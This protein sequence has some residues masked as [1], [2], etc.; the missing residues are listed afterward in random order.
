HQQSRWSYPDQDTVI[1]IAHEFRSRAIP[2]DTIVLDID[3]MEDYRVF[4]HSKERF[5]DFKQMV[6]DLDNNGFKIVTIIDPGVKKDAKYFVFNDGKKHGFFCAKAD[7][8]PF[9]A[10]VWPGQSAF[11]DFVRE[12]VRTWWAAQHGFHTEM[13]VAGIWNDMNEPSMFDQ[14][15]PIELTATELPPD[16]KQLFM[17]HAPEGA[18]G[19]FEVRNLYGFQMSRS[20]HQ[21]LL[22]L[23][24]NE[25]PFVL[26][27]S[28]YAGIQRY[29]AVW[30]GDN[31]S[32]WGHLG[33]SIPMLLNMGLCGVPFA[34]VDVGGFALDCSAELLVRWYALGIFYPFFRNHCSMHGSPQ[35]PWVFSEEVEKHCRHLIEQR[36][37]LIP[38][39]QRLFAEHVRTGAPLMRPLSWHYPED[40][41]A[42]QIDDQFLFGEDILVAPIVQRG[43]TQRSV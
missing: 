11:P 41:F 35:E 2:C 3:Y 33:L 32:W 23:R 36:Y 29:A 37:R 10:E 18:V 1:R 31:S 22:A 20:T 5:P 7:G 21:G 15:D 19:H 12:D 26:S 43:T 40:E 25:R 30:L 16:S 9:L 24:P 34:G 28:G 14:P 13:G 27:R 4:T 42:A 8:K 17:Q 6:A 39:I 38:H